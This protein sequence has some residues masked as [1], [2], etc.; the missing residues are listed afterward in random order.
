M[1]TLEIEWRHLEKDG[2]TCLRCSDTLQSLQQVIARLAVECGPR[3]VR[4]EYRETKLLSEQ[5]SQ[6][7][8]I[9]FNGIPL[10]SVLPGASVA[11]TECPSCG[12][13]TGQPAF[14][15]TVSV[16]GHTFEAIPAA[17]VRQAACAVAQC[18]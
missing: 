7:N 11:E 14:C 9:L 8:L 17:L 16:G 3:G 2:R 13:L 1:K 10:E 5:L 15:R 4:V 18:C 12:D 6:S